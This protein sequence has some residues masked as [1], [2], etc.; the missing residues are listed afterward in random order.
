MK[1][2]HNKYKKKLNFS[3]QLIKKGLYGFK[4]NGFYQISENLQTVLLTSILKKSKKKKIWKS[5]TFNK[6]LTKLTSESRMGKG[7]GMIYT[8]AMFVKPGNILLELDKT[9]YTES[10]NLYKLID[11]KITKRIIFSQRY[12]F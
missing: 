9:T 7:K 1:K 6:S 5:V 4:I 11:K 2:T 10:F 8:K 12:G 3:N